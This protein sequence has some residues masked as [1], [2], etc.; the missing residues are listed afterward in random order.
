MNDVGQKISLL[1]ELDSISKIHIL[2]R[3]TIDD[4]MIEFAQRI[5]RG[6][7][8]ERMNVWLFDKKDEILV[9]VGEYDQRTKRFEKN[10]LLHVKD[11]PL[12]FKVLKENKLIIVNDLN[13]HPFP[14]GFVE[15]Y[16]KPNNII[17]SM[18][19]PIR[20]A[21]ELVGVM[22]FEKTGTEPRVFKENERTFAFSIALV[23]AS[24]LEARQRRSVQHLLEASLEEKDL[25]I[26]EMNHRVKNNFS[27]L[28]SLLRISKDRIADEEAKVV[29]EEYERRVF[30]M[31]KIHDLLYESGNYS[32]VNLVDYLNELVI[33]FKKSH[34]NLAKAITNKVN[35][36][37][38]VINSKTVVH[39]GLLITEIFLN[40]IKYVSF[41]HNDYYF[42]I[43]FTALGNGDHQLEIRDSGEGFDFD[44]KLKTQTLGVSLIRDLVKDLGYK[45]NFP[46]KGNSAYTFTIIHSK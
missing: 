23:F 25:L 1:E 32:E 22:C 2:Q 42:T 10:T 15:H 24:N 18:V 29:L 30:S 20:I 9:S 37:N 46:T 45:A 16:A 36:N 5:T 4:I 33:E 31:V 11:F 21:G 17:S 40:S 26:R 27:I 12:Y 28:I 44:E 35:V 19:V 8:I 7:A 38:Y 34:P 6:L 39:L 43:D 13:D 14:K 3:E 41:N